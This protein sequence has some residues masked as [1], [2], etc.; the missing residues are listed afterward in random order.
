MKRSLPLYLLLPLLLAACAAQ[1]PSGAVPLATPSQTPDPVLFHAGAESANMTAQYYNSKMTATAE[2]Q[3]SAATARAWDVQAM[4][5]AADIT[6][7]ARAWELTVAADMAI[8]TATAAAQQTAQAME[9]AMTQDA[10]SITATANYANARTY[11]TAM[12]SEAQSA[13]N[14][15]ERDEMTNILQAFLPFVLL[16]VSAWVGFKLLYHRGRTIVVHRDPRGDAPL[17]GDLIEGVVFDPDRNFHPAGSYRSAKALPA[18]SAAQQAAV[19]ERDQLL[20][21]ATRGSGAPK[22]R[23]SLPGQTPAP[24]SEENKTA[25]KV[26]PPQDVQARLQDVIPTMMLDAVVDGEIVE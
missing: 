4:Q 26:L 12:A 3:Q 15:V 2:A 14:A 11:S 24:A 17:L 1:P 18:P 21:L 22:G 9:I 6:S 23:A 10:A 20:D 5:A 25:I 16:A 19:T 8:S 13:Q 7:T